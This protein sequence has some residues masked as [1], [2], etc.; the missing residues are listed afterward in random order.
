MQVIHL[1][2]K[3]T[4]FKYHDTLVTQEINRAPDKRGNEDNSKIIFLFLNENICWDALLELSR[5][6]G[7][8]GGSQNMLL[9][10]N[11]ANYPYIALNKLVP[12][13][14]IIVKYE[15]N[16]HMKSSELNKTK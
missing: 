3:F 9:W 13:K 2:E 1:N 7:S 4:V 16:C 6:E 15:L 12:K 8:N 10:R 11:M 5:R 14:Y